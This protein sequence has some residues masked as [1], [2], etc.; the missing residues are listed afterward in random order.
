MLLSQW[1]RISSATSDCLETIVNNSDVS[2]V[3]AS[4]TE[5]PATRTVGESW[6]HCLT[7]IP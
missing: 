1:H 2:G 7:P 6:R 3:S 5:L 4:N